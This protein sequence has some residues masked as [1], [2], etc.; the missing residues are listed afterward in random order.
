[1]YHSQLLQNTGLELLLI[2][3][4]KYLRIS[5]SFFAGCLICLA[6]LIVFGQTN[7]IDSLRRQLKEDSAY[8]FRPKKL[9]VLLSLDQRNTFLETKT[10]NNTPVFLRGV[11]MGLIIY[12][13]HKTGLG[14]YSLANNKRHISRVDGKPVDIDFTFSYVTL[15]YEYYFI[16]T[17]RWDLGIPFDIGAGEYQAIDPTEH[18]EGVVFPIGTAVDVHYKPIRW[19]SINAMGGY[20]QV[21]NNYTEINL[22]NWFYSWGFSIN[23]RNVYEDSRYYLKKRKYRKDVAALTLHKR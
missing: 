21:I 18:L 10:A 9:K 4:K 15:F 16:H 8:I 2:F 6:P 20:R 7:K 23:T 5:F 17:R 19:L 14:F 12:E 11:K 1:V 22:S 13:R 3:A